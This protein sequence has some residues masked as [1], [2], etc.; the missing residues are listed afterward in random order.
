MEARPVLSG[1]IQCLLANAGQNVSMTE[2]EVATGYGRHQLRSALA[3]LTK[4]VGMRFGRRNWCFRM[5]YNLGDSG[6]ASY[7]MSPDIAA[8][9]TRG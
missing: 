8:M 3:G 6:E 9:W 4:H 5:N 7:I 2:Y 1:L